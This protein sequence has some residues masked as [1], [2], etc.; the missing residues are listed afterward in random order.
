MIKF[1][2]RQFVNHVKVLIWIGTF[3]LM[4]NLLACRQPASLEPKTRPSGVPGDAVWAG[5]ADGGA[6]V[7][8]TADVIHDVNLC[9]VWNDYTGGSI[10]PGKYRLEKENRAA[11]VSELRITGAV[12]E[13]IY[14]QGGLV[15]KRL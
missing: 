7:R 5:G 4:L 2:P 10:G 6:Y 12:N 1:N 15:L 11:T 3:F 8:C 14:L 9:T 13:F